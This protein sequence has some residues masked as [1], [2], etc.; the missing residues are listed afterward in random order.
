M[1]K[2]LFGQL[3][4]SIPVFLARIRLNWCR[5][6]RKNVHKPYTVKNGPRTAGDGEPVRRGEKH[7]RLTNKLTK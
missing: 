5:E 6:N 4:E 3:S 1:Y 7:N 2:S